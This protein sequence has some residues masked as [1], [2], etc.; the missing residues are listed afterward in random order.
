MSLLEF[1]GLRNL[2]SHG[3]D[4]MCSWMEKKY[5]NLLKHCFYYKKIYVYGAGTIAKEVVGILTEN[6]VLCDGII[7]TKCEGNKSFGNL[8]MMSIEEFAQ[9][10][11]KQ[12]VILVCVNKKIENEILNTLHIFGIK[13]Y[14]LAGRISFSYYN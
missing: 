9:L 1:H 14:Y 7:V 6:N 2:L 13:E 10:Y 12:D 8:K 11:D 5:L 3:K 4:Y